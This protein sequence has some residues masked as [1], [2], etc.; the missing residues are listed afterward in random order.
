MGGNGGKK[1]SLPSYLVSKGS[2]HERR[3][4]III[5]FVHS[6]HHD[7]VPDDS[8]MLSYGHCHVEGVG[9]IM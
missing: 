6:K 3:S 2:K 4:L 7:Q 8:W 9:V 1:T 5:S